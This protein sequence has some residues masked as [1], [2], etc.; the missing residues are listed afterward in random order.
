MRRWF[1]GCGMNPDRWNPAATG[2]EWEVTPE[3]AQISLAAANAVVQNNHTRHD[4][5][6]R[7]T[8]RGGVPVK[9]VLSNQ[10]RRILPGMTARVQVPVSEPR[11]GLDP[12]G[13]YFETSLLVNFGTIVIHIDIAD[14][15]ENQGLPVVTDFLDLVNAAHHGQFGFGESRQSVS[16]HRHGVESAL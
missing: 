13:Q 16:L 15:A 1:W 10:K 5:T 6:L 7:P 14:F 12:V 4:K 2:A 3:L 8:K 11:Q 9:V